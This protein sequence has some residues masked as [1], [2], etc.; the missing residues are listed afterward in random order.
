MLIL[1]VTKFLQSAF[2]RI[3]SLFRNK[4]FVRAAVVYLLSLA[5]GVVG[6]FALGE[7]GWYALT[8][9]PGLGSGF[10]LALLNNGH[11]KPVTYQ[12]VISTI[13]MS[14]MITVIMILLRAPIA[15]VALGMG[16]S[17]LGSYLGFIFCKWENRKAVE[18]GGEII[19]IFDTEKN[20][21]GEMEKPEAHDKHQWH[22][23]VHIWV[24]DGERV[25]VQLRS[26]RKKVFPNTW[27]V[28]VGGHFVSGDTPQE[29]A[30]REWEEELGTPWEFGEPE[31]DSEV[32]PLEICGGQAIFEFVYFFFLKCEFDTQRAKLLTAEVS[33]IK[34]LPFE[35]FKQ[36]IY[37]DEFIP[38]GDDYWEFV[39]RKLENLIMKK[40]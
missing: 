19:D 28:S 5:L 24:T 38:Y 40:N 15:S 32:K 27:D 26:P 6:F 7:H 23:N 4:N 22:K 20:K 30:A 16:L 3:K 36:K 34:W 2:E 35:T 21:I 18:A 1:H 39:V 29:C 8:C 17:F 37:T 14:V 13:F 33:E 12:S 11:K 25:L 9:A 31:A 10:A